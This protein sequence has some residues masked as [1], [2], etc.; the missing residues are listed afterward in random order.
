[1]ETVQQTTPVVCL[2]HIKV[3]QNNCITEFLP[4]FLDAQLWCQTDPFFAF[5]RRLPI[6][7]KWT[8]ECIDLKCFG[9]LS[10][11]FGGGLR[12]KQLLWKRAEGSG[13]PKACDRWICH[14]CRQCS[15]HI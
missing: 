11:V 7:T 1:M 13:Q 9:N 15:H 8:S 4:Y 6:E 2:P 12:F 10:Q 5:R 3:M 14:W